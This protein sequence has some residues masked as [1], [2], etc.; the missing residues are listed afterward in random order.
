M[1]KLNRDDDL[2]KQLIRIFVVEATEYIE[3]IN[4]KLL[5]LE[6]E[7]ESENASSAINELLREAHSLKGA[8]RAV[9]ILEIETLSHHLENIFV[10]MR[11]HNLA[12]SAEDFDLLFKAVD[13][14]GLLVQKASGAA[15]STPDTGVLIDQLDKLAAANG[16]ERSAKGEGR[17][18]Q[19]WEAENH[20]NSGPKPVNDEEH[21]PIDDGKGILQQTLRKDETIRLSTNRLDVLLSSMSE[22]HA[23]RIETKQHITDLAELYD[24]MSLWEK[25]WHRLNSK[26]QKEAVVKRSILHDSSADSSAQS[27]KANWFAPDGIYTKIAQLNNTNIKNSNHQINSIIHALKTNERK[28]DQL[29]MEME[30][31]IRRTRMLPISTIINAFPRV[32]R[33]LARQCGKEITLKI[34]GEDTEVD[35]AVLEQIKDPLLHLVRNC[36][37]HGIESPE[38]R[39]EKGKPAKGIIQIKA[40]QQG[41]NLILEVNDDGTGIDLETIKEIA[42]RKKFLTKKIC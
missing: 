22:L 15:E 20:L 2:Q 32:V 13:S 6:K 11:D 31:E 1:P 42:I 34:E 8:A 21:Q 12:L 35:R 36:V 41:S 25:Q 29:A 16:R 39:L 4:Q 24:T 27:D 37:D 14:I 38:A 18:D 19:H 3:A 40:T 33:D 9:N 5:V 28:I 23:A 17:I 26:F 30:E 10:S 7:P